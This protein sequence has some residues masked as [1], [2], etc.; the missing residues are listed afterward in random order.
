MVDL[1]F[2]KTQRAPFLGF[3]NLGPGAIFHVAA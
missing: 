3:W 2:W 1:P